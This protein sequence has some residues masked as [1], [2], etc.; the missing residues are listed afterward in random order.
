[1]RI[2]DAITRRLNAQG[3]LGTRFATPEEVVRWQLAVQAQDYPGAKWSLGQ[4][5]SGVDDAALDRLFDEGRILRTHVMRPTWHFV[6]P[7]DLRWLLA[8]TAPRVHATNKGR[9]AELGL[10]ERTRARGGEVI[11][12]AI[13]DAGPRTRQ[14]LGEALAAAGIDPAG[15]RLAHLVMHAEL[16]AVVCSGPRRGKQHTYALFD[17]RVPPGGE[18]DRE[19]E[20]VAELVQRYVASHGPA[21]PHDI[22]WW[23][24]L[25]VSDARRG[26]AM[27][28]SQLARTAIDGVEWWHTPEEPSRRS[29]GPLVHLLQPWDEYVL[30]FNARNPAWPPEIRAMQGPKGKL[31]NASLIAVDGLVAGGWRRKLLAR[32]S[33]IATILPRPL[34]ADQRAALEREVERYGRFLGLPVVMEDEL[35]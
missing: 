12:R 15:Q 34:A 27:V 11:H 20:G 25:T 13:A 21:T 18:R 2:A 10:D 7:E 24:G 22:A 19:E 6:L 35:S 1:M 23:S 4:R 17:E 14:E 32:E 5:L 31:W 33:R 16:E 30:G 29:R 26:L 28:E 9:Y 3:L 8:L